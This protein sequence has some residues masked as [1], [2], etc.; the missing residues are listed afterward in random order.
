MGV[1]YLHTGEIMKARTH[2][3][4]IALYEPAE[5]RRGATRF[6]QDVRVARFSIGH[7]RCGSLAIRRSRFPDAA[8]S[9]VDARDIGQAATVM[10]ALTLTSLTHIHCGSY[11]AAKEQFDEAIALADEK[12]AMFWKVGGMLVA[13]CVLALLA[14][15]RTPFP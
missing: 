10:A 9:V 14:K 6:G 5:H 7:S 15:L 13:G 2:R 8:R 4:A 11:P 3:Q 12:G 1:S